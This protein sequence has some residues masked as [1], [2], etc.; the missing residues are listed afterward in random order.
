MMC[1]NQVLDFFITFVPRMEQQLRK[2]FLFSFIFQFRA[3]ISSRKKK[4]YVIYYFLYV[5]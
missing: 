1:L 2:L 4:V 3:I 5:H